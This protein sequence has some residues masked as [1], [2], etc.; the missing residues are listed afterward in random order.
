MVLSDKVYKILKWSGLIITNGLVAFWLAIVKL[1]NI[2]YGTEI[3]GTI[4]AIGTLI[5]IIVKVSNGNY[6]GDGTIEVNTTDP[7]KDVYTLN[8]NGDLNEIASKKSVTF[9]VANPDEKK[10]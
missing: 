3:G 8:Y 4:A 6:Q 2:P 5:G 7:N 9:M 1:W 10:E